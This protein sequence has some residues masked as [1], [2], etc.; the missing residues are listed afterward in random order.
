MQASEREKVELQH[1]IREIERKFAEN[2]L[3]KSALK[4]QIN[5]TLPIIKNFLRLELIEVKM[6]DEAIDLR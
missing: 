5:N 2:H 3:Q 4:T 1:Q 6:N